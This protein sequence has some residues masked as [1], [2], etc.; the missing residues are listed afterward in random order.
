MVAPQSRVDVP[1]HVTVAA[2]E[3]AYVTLAAV[4]QG[5]LQLTG[6]TSPNPEDHYFGKRR[7]GLDMRDDYGRLIEAQAGAVGTIRSGGDALGGA[8][9]TVVPIRTVALF[10]G[11]VQAGPDGVA[12]VSFDIPDFAGELRLMAVAVTATRVGQAEVPLTIRDPL[13][14]E[15]SLPRFL[16]PGD[17]ALA[18]LSMHNVDGAPGTYSATV[19]FTEGLSSD[20]ASFTF[21]LGVGERREARVPIDALE[22]GVATI[23]LNLS[24]PDGFERER[25]WPIEVR[26]AQRPE[27]REDINVLAAG[28]SWD[29]PGD[30]VAGLVPA[31]TSVALSL[32]TTRGL[33]AGGL[34]RALDRYPFGCLEQTVSRAFPLLYMDELAT[35]A[36][37]EFDEGLHVRQQNAINRVLDMQRSN[38]AFGMWGAQGSEAETWLSI[39]AVDFLTQAETQGYIVPD[40]ALRRGLEWVANTA[41]QSWRDNQVRAYGYYVLARQGRAVPGDVRYFHDTARAQMTDVMALAYLGGALDALGDRARGASSFDRAMRLMEEADP[42]SYQPFRYG[43]LTRDVAILTT[44]AARGQRTGLLPALFDRID[45][46]AP[47]LRYTTTQEQTWLL[48][49]AQAL[50]QSAAPLDVRVAGAAASDRGRDPLTVVLTLAEV[51]EGVQVLNNGADI[52]RGLTVIGIPAA[53]Q[54]A[55]ADGLTLSRSFHQLDGTPADLAALTQNDRIVVLIEGRLSDNYFREMALLDLLP[56]GFEIESVAFGGQYGWLP[57]LTPTRM[58]QARD[59]LFVAAFDIGNR[60]RPTEP[61]SEGRPIEPPFAVAYVARAIT[62]GTFV[63]PPAYVEDMYQPRVAGQTAMGTIIIAESN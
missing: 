19:E 32:S 50:T 38:G 58:A 60:S 55:Q 14:G 40:D 47:R 37:L 27:T 42:R 28:A 12:T 61:D 17:E 21:D 5:I 18:T 1:I 8:G 46:L 4:D 54:D 20:A 59:D 48:F 13:V 9:L 49:A 62:P 34:L 44:M 63:L 11:L 6:F 43:S 41:T 16:A 22:L 2:G 51:S 36:G 26:P 57:R 29:V 31:T 53:P 23:T 39:F 24:G 35:E 33:D 10:S 7:L 56:A 25:T 30:A 45:T 15:L 52:W 3:T